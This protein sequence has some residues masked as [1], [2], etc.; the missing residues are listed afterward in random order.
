MSAPRI[1]LRAGRM[2]FRA[3]PARGNLLSNR[4]RMS[5]SSAVK[6]ADYEPIHNKEVP[7]TTFTPGSGVEH[8][9]LVVDGVPAPDPSATVDSIV[10]MT[11]AM[12]DQMSHTSKQASVFGKIIIITG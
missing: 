7:T 8:S 11:Q 1:L 4:A 6:K 9:T 2:A 10:P 3:A 5:I 12:Y